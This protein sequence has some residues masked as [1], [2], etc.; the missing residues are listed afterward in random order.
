MAAVVSA[1]VLAIPF[2]GANAQ[3]SREEPRDTALFRTVASLDSA[4]FDA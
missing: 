2:A 3:G 4:L 1:A